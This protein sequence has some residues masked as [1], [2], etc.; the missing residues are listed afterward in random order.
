MVRPE[1]LNACK[2]MLE[3]RLQELKQTLKDHFGVEMSYNKDAVGE[4]SNY[5]NH[6]GDTATELF[7]REKDIALNDHLEQEQQDIEAAL[8][9][10]EKGTYGICQKSGKPIPDERLLAM[11][12]AETLVE[13]KPQQMTLHDRPAE[14]AVIHPRLEDLEGK[15]DEEDSEHNFYDG[16]DTLQE[17]QAYGS[18]ETPSD[19]VN[20]EKDYEY[21]AVNSG[22]EVGGA[23]DI[24]NFLIADMH[25]KYD[26]VNEDHENYEDYLDD[27]DVKSILYD[28]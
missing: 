12:T 25:G 23:E 21:M 15:D 16:E 3:K 26:G 5:D 17:L 28:E 2:E 6:P 11:P 7:E 19:F 9:R 13:F 4:L 27:A 14:E 22:E 20:S 1:T 24:E 18:S 10:M 8:E